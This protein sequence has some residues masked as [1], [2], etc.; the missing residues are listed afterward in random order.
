MS[1]KT[2]SQLPKKNTVNQ[3][4]A[5]TIVHKPFSTGKINIFNPPRSNPNGQ[6]A[7]SKLVLNAVLEKPETENIEAIDYIP[8]KSDAADRTNN[9]STDAVSHGWRSNLGNFWSISAIAIFLAINF[10][11]SAIIFHKS[12]QTNAKTNTKELFSQVGHGDLNSQEFIP[13]NLSTLST[14]STKKDVVE[15]SEKTEKIAPDAPI[16]PG[17][18]SLD[19]T[20]LLTGQSQYHYVLTEYTGER[21]LKSAKEKVDRI[22]LVNFPQGVFIYLGAFTQKKQA[23]AFIEQLKTE[24]LDAYLYPFD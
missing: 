21:S 14:I 22:S 13:L 2:S 3:K 4:V 7:A 9:R 8:E 6:Q 19:S 17:L 15:I 11:S 16:H 1:Q 20:N 23:T 10:V 12:Q 24:G 5:S 18:T